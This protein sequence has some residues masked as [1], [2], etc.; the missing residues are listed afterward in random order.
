MSFV[1]FDSEKSFVINLKPYRAKKFQEEVT[2]FYGAQ[3]ALGL[4]HIH[5]MGLVYRDLKPEN[6][7]L[8]YKGFLKITDFGFCKKIKERTYTLCGTP[9]YIA[10]EI[11]QNK[12]YGQSVDWWSFGILLYE[13]SAGYSPF[14]IGDPSQMEMFEKIC[15]GEFKCPSSFNLNQKHLIQHLVQTDLTKRY[16]NLKNGVEDIKGHTWFKTINWME[17]Y[18]QSMKPSFV[19]KVSGPGDYSQFDKF[20]A[21]P[22]NVALVDKYVKEFADFWA[23][24]SG[25]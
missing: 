25:H 16:G 9:E 4:E 23:K 5:K 14:S 18:N 11:I 21:A 24:L 12:G 22:L 19:P 2:K 8:D 20:D 13:M 17:L 15:S 1:S 3:I 10:P 6:I 7:M